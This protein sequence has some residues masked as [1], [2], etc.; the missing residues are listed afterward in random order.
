MKVIIRGMR[1]FLFKIEGN[2]SK[3]AFKKMQLLIYK[4][5]LKFNLIYYYLSDETIT[6]IKEISNNVNSHPQF[7][8]NGI[9]SQMFEKR[10]DESE[11][12][13]EGEG[14]NSF[15]RYSHKKYIS[16]FETKFS[17]NLSNNSNQSNSKDSK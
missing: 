13:D 8:K 15:E 6:K 16:P 7:G 14:I 12:D 17:G 10:D 11:Y 1:K 3:Y 2:N 4:I 9:I 5:M